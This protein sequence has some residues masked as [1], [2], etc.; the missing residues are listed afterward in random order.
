LNT[1]LSTADIDDP[2]HGVLLDDNNLHAL[3]S[4]DAFPSNIWAISMKRNN[5]SAL[6]LYDWSATS[7]VY[8]SMELWLDLSENDIESLP[9]Q[10]LSGTMATFYY[11]YV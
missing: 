1:H 2:I 4:L 5:L 7:N 6:P 9:A 8:E 10:F 3:P 11:T